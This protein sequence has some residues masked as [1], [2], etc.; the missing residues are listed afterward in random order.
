MTDP[1]PERWKAVRLKFFTSRLYGLSQPPEYQSEGLP[2]VRATNI[3][4]G[5]LVHDGLVFV[6]EADLSEPRAVRLMTGDIIVVRSGAYTGDSALVTTDWVGGVA[7]FDIVVRVNR[8]AHP[9]FVAFSLLSPS[10]LEQQIEPM[11]SRA[12]QPHLNAEELGDVEL[13]LPPLEEQR[14]I[15]DYLGR[16]MGRLDGL[17]AAKERLLGL[18]AEK[19]RALI[20]RAV[21]RGIDPLAPLRDSDIPWLGEIPAHWGIWKVGH[22][23]VVGNGS[24]PSRDNAEYWTEGLIPWL[25]SS[26]VNQEEVTEADQFI[27]EKAFRECHLPLVKSG[28]VLVGITGQGKTRGQAVVLSFEA[29]INQHLAFITPKK[30]VVN[31]WFLRWAFFAAY[32]FLR[33]ISDDAGGTKGALTCEEVSALRMPL[34]PFDEQRAIV[35]HITTETAKLDALRAATE[36]T[37]ALLKEHRAALIAAAVTGKINVQREIA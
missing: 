11:R 30:G 23:A 24:T 1:L 35:A 2:F 21:T 36:R 15:A 7:G 20:T 9:Q 19:R 28:S 12:A 27:T 5:K 13:L 3:F 37:I 29:T 26:V 17:V 14:A 33:S 18:L 32:D 31:P 16:E 8:Y 10:V 6:S 22:F 4:R 34:P 25:N